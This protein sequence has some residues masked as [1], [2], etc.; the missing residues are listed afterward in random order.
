MALS[1]DTKRL[2]KRFRLVWDRD[3]KEIIM[4]GESVTYTAH[5]CFEADTRE[6]IE[7]KIKELGLKEKEIEFEPIIRR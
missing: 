2:T 1:K 5:P 3:S 4:K 7:A 6:E